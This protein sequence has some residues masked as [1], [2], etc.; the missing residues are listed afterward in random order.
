MVIVERKE[1]KVQSEKEPLVSAGSNRLIEP[2][3]EFWYRSDWPVMNVAYE[4]F[5]YGRQLRLH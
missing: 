3:S 5:N 1:K 4:V 2:T